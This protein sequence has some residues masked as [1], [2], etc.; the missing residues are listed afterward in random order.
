MLLVYLLTLLP[1]SFQPLSSGIEVGRMRRGENMS[2]PHES[3]QCKA[4]GLLA[5]V[6][7]LSVRT[8]GLAQG[9]W[10]RVQVL[11]RAIQ[12]LLGHI[13]CHG[14][15]AAAYPPP[16]PKPSPQRPP[17][18]LAALLTPVQNLREHVIPSF[19][20]SHS[21]LMRPLLFPL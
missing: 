10:P 18:S 4:A 19:N 9:P 15:Q 17:H 5:I 20:R 21:S 6:A 8:A 7:S 14:R 12:G 11:E 3:S 16:S 13:L 2:F 1:S